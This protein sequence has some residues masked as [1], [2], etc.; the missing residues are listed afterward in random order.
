LKD[1]GTL[2]MPQH[3]SKHTC[4]VSITQHTDEE[5]PT[6]PQS[7]W[8][9]EYSHKGT[10]IFSACKLT[11]AHKQAEN[12]EATNMGSRAVFFIESCSI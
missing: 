6:N 9:V 4:T 2:F 8:Q 1:I 7:A 3:A 5:P 12:K 10:D 11:R